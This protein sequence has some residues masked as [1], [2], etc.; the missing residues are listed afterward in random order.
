MRTIAGGTEAGD[1]GKAAD[2]SVRYLQGVATDA[3]GNIYISDADDHR[4]RRVDPSGRITTLAGDGIPGF[5]GDGGP[6]SS[7]RLNTPYGLTVTPLGDVVFADLGNARVRRI[8]SSGQ[9]ETIAGGGVRQLPAAGQFL[10]PREVKLIAPRNVLATASGSIF[11]SDF[12]AN[13]ILEIRSDGNMTAMPLSAL[14]LNAPAGLTLDADGNLVVADSGNAR[15]RRI[16]RDGRVDILLSSS[17]ALPLERP[18]GLART[19]N[20]SL[21]IADTR[22]DYLW[23]FDSAGRSTI[24]PPGGR[25]VAVDRSGN[26]VTAGAT[27]LRRINPQGLIEILIGSTYAKYRGDGGQALAARLNHPTGVAVNSKGAVYFSDTGNHRV[28][29]IQSDGVIT[30]VAGTG[31]PGFRG[32]GGPAVDAYLNHP[33]HLAVDAFDNLYVSDTGNHRVRVLSP[34]GSIQTFAGTGKTIFSND[35]LPAAQSNLSSPSGLAID[36]AGALFIAEPGQH[37]IRK[38]NASGIMTTIAGNS[39]R[40]YAGDG[41]AALSATLNSPG[42]LG[43]DAQGNLWIADTGNQAIRVVE[44]SSGKIRTQASDIRG[45]AGLAVTPTGVAYINESQ[46]HRTL[47]IALDGTVNTIAGRLNENGFNADSGDAAALTLN[48]PA[49]I[50]LAPDGSLVLA[51]QLNDRLRRIIPPAELQTGNSQRIRVVHAATFLEGPIAPGQ[52]LSLLASE[53]PTPELAAITFDGVAARVSFANASQMNFQVPYSIAGRTSVNLELRIGG[54]LVHRAQLPVS[55]CAPGFFES[56]GLVVALS[57]DGR[58]NSELNPAGTGDYLTLYATGEGLLREASGFQVPFLPASVEVGG[59]PAEV[60][61]LGAAPGFSGLL[62]VN[63]RLPANIRL[64]G[65][66]P[67]TLKIGAFQNPPN[68]LLVVQ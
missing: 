40:G 37:R 46:R 63:L 60:L 42:A 65:R 61:Y 53:L 17:S 52:W 24:L 8:R 54:A 45:A 62:Q 66:V 68:Q 10:P 2:A 27:W 28:R 23:Q 67:V 57:P 44:A 34:G 33:T 49:A 38:V 35:G 55:A 59:L 16:R 50:A 4:V 29:R 31:D 32:D 13:Q 20:G 18:V 39:L 3:V 30:T 14:E 12:G 41:Q 1:G 22:G 25:D 11:I 19:A 7:A 58:L 9:I 6:A 36:S 43:I 64:R 51:D 47:R 26:I 5:S 15:I 48:E 56:A 21:L